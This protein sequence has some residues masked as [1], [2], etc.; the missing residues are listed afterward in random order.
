MN[1]RNTLIMKFNDTKT[2]IELTRELLNVSCENYTYAV[3][4]HEDNEW[5]TKIEECDI[6]IPK[7][8]SA[9]FGSNLFNEIL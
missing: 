8:L 4:Q 5:V 3:N 9:A 2:N 1:E 6:T 7:Y